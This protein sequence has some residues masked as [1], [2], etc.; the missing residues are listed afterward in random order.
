MKK[1]VCEMCGS[2]D[3]VKQDGLFVCQSCGMK[4]SLEE[5]RKLMIEGTVNVAGTVSIDHSNM[6]ENYKKMMDVAS[7]SQNYAQAEQYANKV[8]E[9]DPTN[10]NAWFTK[11]KAI[12]W[13]HTVKNNRFSEALY[14]FRM[15]FENSNEDNKESLIKETAE[16]L[17]NLFLAVSALHCGF[18][19]KDYS[20]ETITEY[21]GSIKVLDNDLAEFFLD[22]PAEELQI[23]PETKDAICRNTIGAVMTSWNTVA[24]P[25]YEYQS[26][27][28]GMPTDDDLIELINAE[29]NLVNLLDSITRRYEHSDST[30]ISYARAIIAIY[31]Y[32]IGAKSYVYKTITTTSVWDGSEDYTNKYVESQ[33]MNETAIGMRKARIKNCERIIN[34]GGKFH[35]GQSNE[36]VVV[37]NSLEKKK[38]IMASL[39]END[40]DEEIAN[41]ESQIALLT[42][43]KYDA[44]R[45]MD[46]KIYSIYRS[47]SE[48]SSLKA[49]KQKIVKSYDD[50]IRPLQR[51]L[52]ELKT[53]KL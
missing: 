43:E 23:K 33:A 3:F 46:S 39:G 20:A 52:G 29:E 4:Y 49:E 38:E 16:E 15:A 44:S 5:A 47:P 24:V 34:A 48:Q 19:M 7:R 26:K 9:I 40:L 25:R 21:I 36:I 22:Y 31:S 6:I 12:A 42:K 30:E 14:S 37:G 41:I 53:L 11:G 51:R 50:K 35:R 10:V 28:G 13:Q 2:N 32:S 1:I 17:N 45:E 27:H 18:V 8:I